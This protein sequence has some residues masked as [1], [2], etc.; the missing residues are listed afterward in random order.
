FI[1]DEVWSAVT[2][3]LAVTKGEIILLSTPFGKGGYFYRCFSDP[4]FTSF[5]VSSED[6][7]RISKEFLDQERKRMSN[8]EYAQEYLGEFVDELR[9][10]FPNEVIKKCMNIKRLGCNKFLTDKK[11]LGV[12]IARMGGDE[13]VLVSMALINKKM[14][15][16]DLEVTKNQLLTDT[17][18]QIL[19]ADRIYNYKK[20]YIDDG[21]LGV[22]VFDPLLEHSQTKKKVVPINNSSRALDREDRKKKL[23]KEDLYNNL[24]NLMEQGRCFFFD[25]EDIFHSLRSIQAEYVGDRLRLF[26]NYS[27]ITEAIIRSAWGIKDK[28]LNI[29]IVSC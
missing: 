4:T 11:Y 18:R 20:I 24:L 3:M 27:H 14:F 29:F 17:T 10:F 6:C 1:P 23:L 13:T 9:Q 28:S 26:G 7:P 22:G 5:H 8:L 12:D 21:G 16:V 25:E 2:P 15:M 19:H